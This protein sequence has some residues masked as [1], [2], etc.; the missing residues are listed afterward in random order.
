MLVG[1]RH[2]LYDQED[3]ERGTQGEGEP[4]LAPESGWLADSGRACSPNERRLGDEGNKNGG[5]F[6]CC[7]VSIGVVGHAVSRI[8]TIHSWN[9]HFIGRFRKAPPDESGQGHH[10]AF[11]K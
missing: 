3:E 6:V 4:V 5:C 2:K 8:L 1:L 10:L 9:I 11:T 7:Q